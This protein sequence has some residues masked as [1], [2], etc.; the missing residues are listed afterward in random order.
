MKRFFLMSVATVALFS[1]NVS[2]SPPYGQTYGVPDEDG[3]RI[4]VK[5]NKIF[6]VDDLVKAG[7]K[8]S[9]QFDVTTV[10]GAVEVW[11]GFFN[12][13]NI[14]VRI[15]ESHEISME[16]GKGPAEIILKKKRT[17]LIGSS[18]VSPYP[19]YAIVGNVVM[20]CER[21]LKTCTDLVAELP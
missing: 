3:V 7:Y 21:E 20:L 2:Q 8:K 5:P 14:E 4:V 19:A 18:V 13:K 12:K 17:G 15:F 11:Y 9:K 6:S 10:P 1:C 16:L